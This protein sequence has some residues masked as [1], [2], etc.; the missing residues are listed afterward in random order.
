L[1]WPQIITNSS[2]QQS[3]NV[4]TQP[5]PAQPRPQVNP[6]VTPAV[7]Q[8]TQRR[9]SETASRPKE[10]SQLTTDSSQAE[11]QDR[12]VA[13]E[14]VSATVPQSPAADSTELAQLLVQ[15]QSQWQAGR[16]IAPPG[17]NAFESYRR[18][19]E[20]APDHEEANARLLEIGRMRLGMH[21]QQ[22]ATTLLREGD[23][24]QSLAE[25]QQ[26][27][28]LVPNH[29]GLLALQDK[30]RA[31]LAAVADNDRVNRE[32]SIADLLKQ[33]QRQWQA[34][35][36]TKPPGANAYESYRK[37]LS[38][39]PRNPQALEGL[40]RIGRARLSLRYL[41][42]AKQL[43]QQGSLAASLKTID[44]GL[45]VA[46]NDTKLLELRA[47]IQARLDGTPP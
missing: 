23:L 14:P 10:R 17:D 3:Q 35:Q 43:L 16:W 22:K 8:D 21:Y 19:R 37:V 28:R 26:G 24:A 4:D 15:A 27:L 7:Q 33:A 11:N 38:L 2:Q 42:A 41:R 32:S 12:Q 44:E 5:Q 18:I 34:G 39:D 9:P 36:L 46:P 25:I 31:Q 47:K 40:L 13:T 30:A 6:A 45:R 20:L 29:D 1:P